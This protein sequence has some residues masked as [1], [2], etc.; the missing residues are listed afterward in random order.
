MNQKKKGSCIW[1]ILAPIVVV[2]LLVGG[3]AAC[4][5]SP[6]SKTDTQPQVAD[7]TEEVEVKEE[8]KDFLTLLKENMDS[9]LADHVYSVLT[10][11]IGFE[12]LEYIG[13]SEGNYEIWGDS[14]KMVITAMPATE[15]EPEYIRVFQP[16]GDVY[17]ED[18]QVIISAAEVRKENE[19]YNHTSDYYIIAKS[20]IKEAANTSN[21]MDFPGEIMDA[22]DIAFGWVDDV[23]IVKSYVDI[24]ND[25]G[26]YV[27]YDYLVE[28]VVTDLSTFQYE[29]T[30]LKFAGQEFGTLVS[31]DQLHI[32][33]R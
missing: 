32:I 28:F 5:C 30:Y 20:I 4:F 22:D 10:N 11:D 26:A 27:R 3:C 15:E 8:P 2:F 29:T 25:F 7:K 1:I 23:I 33:R 14:I 18:G 21:P 16:Q 12:T 24:M 17:Y 9:E 19:H 13:L 6:T 31:T